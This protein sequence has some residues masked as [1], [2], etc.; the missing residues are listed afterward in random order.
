[1]EFLS[2][3][4]ISMSYRR[5]KDNDNTDFLSRLLLPPAEKDVS[6]SCSLSDLDNLGV[7]LICAHG[8]VPTSFIIPCL[9]LAWVDWLLCRL[10]PEAL[11]WVD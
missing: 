5:G 10:L 7:Y 2:T 6:G 11:A 8:L 4:N 9:T 3:F 1:M